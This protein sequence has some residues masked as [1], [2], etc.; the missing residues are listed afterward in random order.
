MKKTV[1]VLMSGG[2]DSS[3]AAAILKEA[4]WRVAGFTLRLQ[5]TPAAAEAVADAVA[6]A[7]R[8]GISHRVLDLRP[9]F[10]AR[11]LDPF[12]A[13]YLG[14]ATPNPCTVCNPEIKFGIFLEKALRLDFEKVASGHYARIESRRGSFFLRKG[15]DPER[16]QSYFLYRLRPE[17]LGR[18][19]FPLGR[20]TK[21][22]VRRRAAALGLPNSGKADSQEL[23]FT[24][25][26]GYADLIARRFPGAARPGP[27]YELDG[28]RL[29]EHRGIINYTVGQRSGLGI[30]ASR[31]WYVVRIDP[32]KNALFLGPRPAAYRTRVSVSGVNWIQPPRQ[33]VFRARARIRYR[34][35]EAGVRVECEGDRFQVVFDRPQFAP[36]PGQSLV[37]FRGQRVLG[38]GVIEFEASGEMC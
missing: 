24:A 8:L 32:V 5:D 15:I 31:P 7:D 18:L 16:D 17:S 38:G 28:R 33:P 26:S 12:F 3:V 10:Q 19:L 22:E 9:A 11:V 2:V 27:I 14:G 21:D 6:V 23:C 29:G 25:G 34:S 1:A 35:P 37:L 36:A 4:G 20:L 30:S 13:A